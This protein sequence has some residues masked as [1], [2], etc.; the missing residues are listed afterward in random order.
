MLKQ[1]MESIW[2]SIETYIWNILYNT[3]YAY[4]ESY[5]SNEYDYLIINLSNNELNSIAEYAIQ[6]S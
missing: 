5:M 6:P 3:P 2:E 1:Y 4:I